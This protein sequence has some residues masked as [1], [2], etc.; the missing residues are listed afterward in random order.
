MR[1]VSGSLKQGR[2]EKLHES[3]T[4]KNSNYVL[5]K[6]EIMFHF[7]ESANKTKITDDRFKTF[8]YFIA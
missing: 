4:E 2:Q 7:K 3:E 6:V 8:E 5:N 1:C